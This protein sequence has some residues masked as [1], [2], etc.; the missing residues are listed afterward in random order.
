MLIVPSEVTAAQVVAAVYSTYLIML[1][2]L[3]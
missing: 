1:E 2:P 3:M